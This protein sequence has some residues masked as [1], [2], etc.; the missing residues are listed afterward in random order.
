MYVCNHVC[1]YVYVSIYTPYHTITS[2]N[3]NNPQF[4]YFF[5]PTPATLSLVKGYHIIAQPPQVR[6]AT[7]GVR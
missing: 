4:R 7:T 2:I 1:L 5:L 3:P 6:G